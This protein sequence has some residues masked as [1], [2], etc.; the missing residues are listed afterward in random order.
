MQ[1]YSKHHYMQL[2]LDDVF[3]IEIKNHD[4]LLPETLWELLFMVTHLIIGHSN[5]GGLKKFFIKKIFIN[6]SHECQY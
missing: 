4:V 2:K 1:R 3:R 5:F 6:I